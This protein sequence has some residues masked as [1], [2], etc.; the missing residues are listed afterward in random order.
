LDSQEGELRIELMDGLYL[1]VPI[2]AVL[3]L[4]SA[5]GELFGKLGFQIEAIL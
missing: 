4:P 1:S 3:R 5:A 2:L